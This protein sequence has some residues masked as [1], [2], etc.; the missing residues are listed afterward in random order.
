MTA[1]TTTLPLRAAATAA[2]TAPR[3]PVPIPP[4]GVD[5]RGK[6]VLAPMVRSGELPS[7]LVSLKY[8]ADLVWGPETVDRAVIGTTRRVNP[9]TALVEY[10][11]FS[12]NGGRPEGT[13][14]REAV[15]YRLDPE[16]ER[17]RLIFQLG[18]AS[19]ER[20]VEAARIVAGDVAGIDVNAGC[21][22]PFSTSGGMGAALLKTP[23]RLA[24]ILETLVR[25]VGNPYKIGISVKIRILS[26]PEETEALVSRLC[27]TGITGLTVHCRTTP[28][29][30]RE[31]ALRDQL[32]MIASLCRN[33]GVACLVN[34]DVTSHDQGR[35]LM[36][37]YSVDGAMIATAA[38]SNFSCFR[39]SVDG[40]LAPWREVVHDYVRQAIRCENRWGNTKFLIS[41]MVPGKVLEASGAKQVK[42][43][44]GCCRSLEFDDLIDGARQVD[45][46]MGLVAK[47]RPT[48]AAAQ[49]AN[50]QKKAAEG[51]A[52]AA[53]AKGPSPGSARRASTSSSSTS[54]GTETGTGA[55]TPVDVTS[56]PFSKPQSKPA[57]QPTPNT[58]TA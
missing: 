52:D 26:Q 31:A 14:T 17:G 50:K 36:E 6:I 42:T 13:P 56:P 23:D 57:A 53:V 24:S 11:R 18:T 41:S 19:P 49:K 27:A 55:T 12:S 38:E 2:T 45:E 44:E 3:D 25:D 47:T 46:A 40:G 15:I 21:P 9:R 43:Y 5:Y 58:A 16:R 37:E 32:S 8:G 51:A 33:A 48:T 28:M 35:A 29:R 10:S 20:A 7:R 30:P 22:K 54:P 34:G 4:N 1:M 39:A